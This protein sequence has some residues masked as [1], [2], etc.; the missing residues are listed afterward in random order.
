MGGWPHL[1]FG[2]QVNNDGMAG[3]VPAFLL[4]RVIA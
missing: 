4:L 3:A 2:N 1:F